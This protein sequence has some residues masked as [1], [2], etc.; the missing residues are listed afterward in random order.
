[1][2][3]ADSYDECEPGLNLQYMKISDVFLV[4]TSSCVSPIEMIRVKLQ[5]GKELKYKG[6]YILKRFVD[7]NSKWNFL[8][9]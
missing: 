8:Y 5:S 6:M 2:E 1:M 3:I 9:I 4:I 7:R